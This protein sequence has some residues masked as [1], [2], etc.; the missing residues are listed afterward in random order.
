[1][2]KLCWRVS[3]RDR[4]PW[5]LGTVWYDILVDEWICFPIPLNWPLA[6]GVW[7]W[8]RLRHPAARFRSVWEKEYMKRELFLARKE[9]ADLRQQ[10]ADFLVNQTDTS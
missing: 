7:L 6:V 3:P 9:L 4:S 10:L 1:M 8:K 2:V 5:W